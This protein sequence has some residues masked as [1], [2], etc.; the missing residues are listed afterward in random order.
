MACLADVCCCACI[1]SGYVH[2]P[3]PCRTANSTSATYAGL[4]GPVAQKAPEAL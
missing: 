3:A 2:I 1:H 4:A